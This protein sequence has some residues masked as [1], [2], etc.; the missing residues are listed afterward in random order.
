MRLLGDRTTCRGRTG[1]YRPALCELSAG[2][3]DHAFPEGALTDRRRHQ[4]AAV[5]VEGVVLHRG[6]HRFGEGPVLLVLVAIERRVLVARQ[7]LDA[8]DAVT[9][10]QH[11]LPLGRGPVLDDRG[12]LAVLAG[13]EDDERVAATEGDGVAVDG[14]EVEHADL[15]LLA[16]LVPRLLVEEVLDERTLLHHQAAGT[17]AVRALVVI[18]QR[19]RCVAEVDVRDVARPAED[20]AVAEQ[21]LTELVHRRFDLRILEGHLALGPGDV[22]LLIDHA[23]VDVLDPVG[24]GPAG[25]GVGSEPDAPRRPTVVDRL[26]RQRDEL[27]VGLGDLVAGRFEGRL[28]VEDDRLVVRPPGD[29]VVAAVLAEAEVHPELGVV[30]LHLGDVEVHVLERHRSAERGRA[31]RRRLRRRRDGGRV[32]ALDVHAQRRLERVGTRVGD[33][34]AGDLVVDVDEPGEGITLDVRRGA[35]QGELGAFGFRRRG[36]TG[37]VGGLAATSVVGPLVGGVPG[38]L[39]RALFGRG[40]AGAVVVIVA[41]RCGHQCQRYRDSRQLEPALRHWVSP[42]YVVC[43]RH[44]AGV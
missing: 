4:I 41:A 16:R 5:E 30:D 42:L 35:E 22:G 31:D 20:E 34:R 28:V 36:E 37:R 19:S 32:A 23:A 17:V 9:R 1:E 7:T 33:V 11:A 18:E 15:I 10:G 44:V 14:G 8:F 13:I 26:L 2:E 38:C 21:D 39:V 29:P 43:N 6:G 12:V 40:V 24:A 25:G 27:V 3:L